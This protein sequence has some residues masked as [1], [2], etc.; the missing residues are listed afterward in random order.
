MKFE[1]N[2]KNKEIHS[3]K[4]AFVKLDDENRKNIRILE[5]VIIE[6]NKNKKNLESFKYSPEELESEIKNVLS[7]Y[8]PSEK[9]LGKLVEV[10]SFY[11]NLIILFF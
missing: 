4:I 6:A 2:K 1:V 8:T 3:M 9:L 10:K 5:E 11:L 7:Y